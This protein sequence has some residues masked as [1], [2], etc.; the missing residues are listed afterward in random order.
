[1]KRTS[2]RVVTWVLLAAGLSAV[3]L[4]GCSGSGG[5]DSEPA[6]RGDIAL[7]LTA[8]GR[9]GLTYRL[10]NATFV[11]ESQ[12]HAGAAGAADQNP[13]RIV[14]SS[15]TDP[16]ASSISVPLEE[17]YY[18]VELQPGWHMEK[19]STSGDG[20]AQ[21]VEATLLSGAY[22]SIYVA[23][24]STTWVDYQFGIGGRE[25]WFNG[26]VNITISV[27]E[28]AGGAAGS[29]TGGFGGWA[30]IPAGGVSG[31]QE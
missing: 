1:M 5:K 11:I 20:R 9:S 2:R 18:S 14:V 21:T 3:G 24:R 29:G 23:G 25:V 10:R 8:Q 30:D 28:A 13:G 19:L 31:S 22:Q 26:K 15:E 27:E 16:N 6:E 4:V 12:R 17:G 7:P